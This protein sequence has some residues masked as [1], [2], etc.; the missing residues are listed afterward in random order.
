M[1]ERTWYET[2]SAEG[3]QLLDKV[4]DAIREGNVR[5][6]VIKQKER[7]IAEFPLTVGVVGAVLAPMLAA[8]GAIVALA[9]ECSI[10]IERTTESDTVSA[11]AASQAPPSSQAS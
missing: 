8:I 6:V 7:T 9:T 4:R 1:S 11:G 5:R 3:S 2:I 10:E